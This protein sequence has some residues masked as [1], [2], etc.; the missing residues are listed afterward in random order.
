MNILA[1]LFVLS[2]DISLACNS[3]KVSTVVDLLILP[4]ISLGKCFHHTKTKNSY[5]EKQ[6]KFRIKV[7]TK[8]FLVNFTITKRLITHSK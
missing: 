2:N 1:Y 6:K 4:L 7:F 8:T 5:T 3:L